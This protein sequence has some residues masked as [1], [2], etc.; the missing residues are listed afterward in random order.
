MSTNSIKPEN[1]TNELFIR[2]AYQKDYA[3]AL[4][5]GFPTLPVTT[6]TALYPPL[7]EYLVSLP[8]GESHSTEQPT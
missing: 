5:T 8:G 2:E 4:V 6:P 7:T 3:Q 1:V